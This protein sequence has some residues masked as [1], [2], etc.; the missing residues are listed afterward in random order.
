LR[1]RYAVSFEFQAGPPTTHRGVVEASNVATCVAR[2]T[3]EATK[4]LRPQCW[5]SMV[6]V[7][8]ERLDPA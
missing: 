8:L 4:A 5:K 3:R 7:L 6:C 1:C 2:A